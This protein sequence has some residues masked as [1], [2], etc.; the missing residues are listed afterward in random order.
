MKNYLTML[1]FCMLSCQNTVN[2]SVSGWF[3]LR[4]GSKKMK[5]TVVFAAHLKPLLEKTSQTTVF[6]TRSLKNNV[7]SDVVGRF[8]PLTLQ[9]Q[10]NNHCF[11]SKGTKMS[12][13]AV[14]F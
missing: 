1:F 14:V 4:T 3:A 10:R 6:S 7:N 8:S 11:S 5:K 9:K 2:T 12:L 13:N